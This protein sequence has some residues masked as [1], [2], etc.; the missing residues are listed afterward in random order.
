MQTKCWSLAFPQCLAINCKFPAK[1]AEIFSGAVV[2]C[3]CEFDQVAFPGALLEGAQE[4]LPSAHDPPVG[5]FGAGIV[6]PSLS[7]CQ[8]D[9]QAKPLLEHGGVQAA[10]QQ[11]ERWQ[12]P[13]ALAP[14]F[15][16][17]EPQH[18]ANQTTVNAME[19]VGQGTDKGPCQHAAQ[20]KRSQPPKT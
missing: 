11:Q 3:Q 12:D 6:L 19:K 15:L 20:P 14:C 2:G 18:H 8:F 10:E 4:M 9:S 17:Q 7:L 1:G 5:K 13:A 16:V